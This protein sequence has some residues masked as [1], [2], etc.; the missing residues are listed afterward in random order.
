MNSSETLDWVPSAVLA[1]GPRILGLFES[2]KLTKR[3]PLHHEFCVPQGVEQ[4][5]SYT[6]KELG[7]FKSPEEKY[8]ME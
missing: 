6:G 4:N 5:V 2:R 1:A 8:G 3:R 7:D